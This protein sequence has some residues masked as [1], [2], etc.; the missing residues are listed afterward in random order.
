MLYWNP[1]LHSKV[2]RQLN[3]PYLFDI[4]RFSL[5]DGPGIRTTVFFK[6]CPLRCQWCHNPESQRYQPETME[7]QP[8]QL[9]GKQYPIHQ[10]I[11]LLQADRIFYDQSGGGVTLSG[12]EV[13]AQD[14]DYVEAVVRALR[15]LGISVAVDTS[16]FAPQSHFARILPHTDLFLYDLKLLDD[17]K[18]RRYT[19]V[20]NQQILANL[21]Y[22]SQQGA[23]IDLRLMLAEG[24]NDDRPSIQAVGGWLTSHK[25]QL[26]QISLLPHHQ[27]GREK[28]A[29]LARPA[30]PAFQPPS[31]AAMQWM[32]QYFESTGYPVKRN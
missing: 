11:P 6:G 1:I 8:P 16:G 4:Q 24:V 31:D 26:R 22:L 27:F 13:M 20:S 3:L 29:Q 12:G 25:I 10:L 15:Q 21:E 7:A 14:M 9:M 23:A 30:P 32:Q 2:V 5:H 18:H 17:E 28:Y 19:G